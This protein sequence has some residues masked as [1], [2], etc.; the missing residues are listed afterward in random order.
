MKPSCNDFDYRQRGKVTN[1]FLIN[2]E[3]KSPGMYGG[4]M[5]YDPLWG[6]V[7]EAAHRVEPV[8][9]EGQEPLG[10]VPHV[11]HVL[12][13]R[14][15]DVLALPVP[16]VQGQVAAV[17]VHGVAEHGRHRD[18][19]LALRSRLLHWYCHTSFRSPGS[20]SEEKVSNVNYNVF[21]LWSVA[22]RTL[23]EQILLA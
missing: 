19:S 8:Q 6:V 5:R 13:V 21:Y 12:L 18:G 17:F 3:T 16:G 14:P 20:F 11:L 22:G 9:P 4:H 15:L 10:H 23:F 1:I 7:A 2:S